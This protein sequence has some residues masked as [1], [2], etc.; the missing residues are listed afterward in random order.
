MADRQDAGGSRSIALTFKNVARLEIPWFPRNF[1]SCG[2]N[3]LRP[4]LLP[5]LYL[6]LRI[7]VSSTVV[8]WWSSGLVSGVN[9]SGWMSALWKMSSLNILNFSMFTATG[10]V[11]YYLSMLQNCFGLYFR[12]SGSSNWSFALCL[13][14]L[15]LNVLYAYLVLRSFFP[16]LFFICLYYVFASLHDSSNHGARCFAHLFGLM[17]CFCFCLFST[18]AFIASDIKY[19]S[20][21]LLLFS[22]SLLYFYVISSNPIPNTSVDVCSFHIFALRLYSATQSPCIQW[23]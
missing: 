22:L 12:I 5:A 11:S 2:G 16:C 20:I 9:V 17:F 18:P 6:Y 4:L 3:L 14:Q 10:F 7:S 23:Y 19:S 13:L 15:S 8:I 1:K 21:F